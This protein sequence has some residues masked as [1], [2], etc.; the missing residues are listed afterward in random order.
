[1]SFYIHNGTF[2]SFL[3]CDA[4]LLDA[5]HGASTESG[6]KIS[7]FKPYDDNRIDKLVDNPKLFGFY[8]RCITVRGAYYYKIDISY[9]NKNTE[10]FSYEDSTQEHDYSLYGQKFSICVNKKLK[11]KKPITQIANLYRRHRRT[12]YFQSGTSRYDG[13]KNVMGEGGIN[14]GEAF[15]TVY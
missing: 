11:V 7:A 10:S 9:P 12:N 4:R 8:S 6:D 15:K 3:E 14:M 1:M 13:K 2:V 5:I